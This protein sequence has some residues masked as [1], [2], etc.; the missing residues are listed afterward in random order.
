MSLSNF[1]NQILIANTKMRLISS[2][3]NTRTFNIFKLNIAIEKIIQK[4]H[5]AL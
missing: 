2:M 4:R 5:K 3:D 1:V